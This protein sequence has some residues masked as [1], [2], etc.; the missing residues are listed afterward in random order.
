[1][2]ERLYTE[3]P[4]VYDAIQADWDYDRDV[5]FVR[6]AL[7]RHDVDG[8][9]LLDIGC[10]TGEH[11]RR[12]LDAGFDVTAVDPY[13]GMRSA[14]RSKGDADVRRGALPDLPVDGPYDAAVAIRGVINHLA[15]GELSPA[16]EAVRARLVDGGVLVFDNAPLPA[17]GNHPALAVGST[18]RGD[19]AR[20]AQHVPT[21][22][23]RLDWRS[24][25]FTPSGEWIANSRL[26]TPFGDGTVRAALREA[27]FDVAT[28]DGYGP[29]D[30][31][32]VFVAAA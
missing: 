16:I 17:E 19:L 22:D 11:T 4:E 27:G 30:D 23:G 9:R 12:F 3:H 5:A 2:P 20:I 15:P 7:T 13:E 25:T 29:D 18:D 14:A 24:I 32:T 8:R 26:M 1:M 28:H 31:R 6:D 10:G 21:G